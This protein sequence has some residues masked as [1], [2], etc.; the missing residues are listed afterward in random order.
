MQ[1]QEP[2][3]AKEKRE[4]DLLDA[5][6]INSLGPLMVST[7][8]CDNAYD[9]I[10]VCVETGVGRI[11]VSGL[12]QCFHWGDVKSVMDWSGNVYD[13]DLFYA[14]CKQPLVSHGRVNI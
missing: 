10:V 13:P 6:R 11:F 7:I 8:I 3:I 1:V 2:E 4:T 12:E 9:L 5:E 14:D